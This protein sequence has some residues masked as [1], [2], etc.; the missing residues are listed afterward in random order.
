MYNLEILHSNIE[1]NPENTTRFL[2]I[3]REKIPQSGNDKTSLLIS[4]HDRA[5][6]LLEILAPFAKH[7]ISLTSIETRPALPE[8]WAYV[9]FIDLEGHIDQENVAAAINEIRPMVKE[10][11]I[12]GSYPAAVL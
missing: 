1:D 5:G 11:R 12:L 6:A 3:G 7:N 9:F 2:V 8:K 4:A 10:L